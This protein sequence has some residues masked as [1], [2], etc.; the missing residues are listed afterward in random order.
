MP[1]P[2]QDTASVFKSE[3]T[4][5]AN[6]GL[7]LAGTFHV[8]LVFENTIDGLDQIE[9]LIE[10]AG[11]EFKRQTTPAALEAADAQCSQLLLQTQPHLKKH[12]KPPFT[13]V[14]QY[15]EVKF[16]RQRLLNTQTGKTLTPS[17]ILWQTSQHH[18]ITSATRKAACDA[19]QDASYRKAAKQLAEKAGTEQLISTSTVWNKKQEK[20]KELEQNQNDFVQQVQS[21][22]KV[23]LPVGVPSNSTRRIE[24]GTIQ[25]Q[26]DEVKTKSQEENKKWNLTYTATIETAEGVCYYL[27]GRSVE[28]LT[29]VLM[30]YLMML[31]YMDKSL[32]VVS[33]G[34][35]WISDWV[36]SITQVPVVQILCWF[37]LRKR[38]YESLGAVGLAK[39]QRELL[40]HEILGLLWQG[41]TAQ[42]V[43]ILWELR[44]KSRVPKRID[45]LM[46]YLL[47]K[48][49]LIVDYEA[50]RGES[51]WLA[52]TRVEGWNDTA[53]AD[54]CKHRRASWT[55]SGVLAVALY[56]SQKIHTNS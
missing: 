15:G 23:T 44:S 6:G 29:M 31:G 27:A 10:H 5:T 45:D 40:E 39:E 43:W 36:G 16:K 24:D 34:A 41:K 7:A 53:V 18:H 1:T 21:G 9:A 14:A 35:T 3:V 25:V 51:L 17:A 19:S 46:G 4:Q 30:A 11:Q 33:D 47:R 55:A 20:G 56:Q 54:R 50:R 13:I 12:G 48:K 37:H 8:P 38:I 26:L 42:V 28:Q 2:N 22:K 49:R 52:S 32:E